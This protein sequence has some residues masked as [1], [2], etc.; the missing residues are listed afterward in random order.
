MLSGYTN[1]TALNTLLNAKQNTLTA[2]NNITISNNTISATSGGNPLIL[3]LDGVNQTATTLN[4]IQNDAV[5]SNGVLNVSRLD[6]HDKI[7]LIYS[8]VSSVKDLYQDINSNLIWGT[9]IVA[10]NASLTTTLYAYTTLAFLAT[11]LSHYTTTNSMT[12]ALNAKV[13]DGQVLTNVPANAF[14][15]ILYI[16]N[17]PTNQS[18]ILLVYKL[19]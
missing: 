15:L 11:N 14:S 4:F 5:L 3:Q 8:G 13:D 1:T 17:Q 16:V 9:D 19:H 10:T 18:V 6:F 12:T 2:G 7:P